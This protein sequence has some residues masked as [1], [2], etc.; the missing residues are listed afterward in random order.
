MLTRSM[1]SI[2]FVGLVGIIVH[3]MSHDLHM[4]SWLERH[5]EQPVSVA[6]HYQLPCLSVK[7]R[8]GYQR[9]WLGQRSSRSMEVQEEINFE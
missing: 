6:W 9:S 1:Q 5:S 7:L 3:N 2:R 8:N 4:I